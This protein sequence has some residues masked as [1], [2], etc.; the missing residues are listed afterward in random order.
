MVERRLV[1]GKDRNIIA[2]EKRD[3]RYFVKKIYTVPS[4]KKIRDEL[5]VLPQKKINN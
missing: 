3:Y 4:G 2:S 1:S 5:P